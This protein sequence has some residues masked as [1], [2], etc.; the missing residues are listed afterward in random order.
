M[1]ATDLRIP[2]ASQLSLEYFEV[3][4][5]FK[6]YKY[7]KGNKTNEL[8]G[9]SYIIGDPIFY[10]KISVSVDGDMPSDIAE[11]LKNK[12]Q[13]TYIGFTDAEITFTNRDDKLAMKVTAT[14]AFLKK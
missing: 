11:H 3:T 10:G 1:E 13:K 5:T 8:A 6:R 4:N 12:N 9:Y 2:L 14:K 7:E